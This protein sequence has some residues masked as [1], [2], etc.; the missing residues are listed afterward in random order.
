MKLLSI[1]IIFLFFLFNC[2]KK[3][4]RQRNPE[5]PQG[6]NQS[7]QVDNIHFLSA[8]FSWST[9]EPCSSNFFYWESK[10]Q[11]T[12]SNKNK[13][14]FNKFRQNYSTSLMGLTPETKY[15]FQVLI[16][17]QYNQSVFSDILDF[18]TS[19]DYSN[20]DLKGWRSFENMDYDS[21]AYYFSTYLSYEPK[22]FESLLGY[23]W[24]NIRTNKLDTAENLLESSKIIQND[25]NDVLSG[26]VLKYYMQSN[27]FMAELNGQQIH[28]KALDFKESQPSTY[29]PLKNPYYVFKYDSTYNNLD[30]ALILADSYYYQS[31]IEYA[32]FMVEFLHPNFKL[33]PHLPQSWQ[34]DSINYDTYENALNA[35]IDSLKNDYWDGDKHP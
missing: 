21:A 32:S 1:S 18:T 11:V 28:E 9:I 6:F 26:F 14:L 5:K 27:F 23:A 16:V 8:D 19:L 34:V 30:I 17:N 35:L 7:P 29:N 2:E 31:N 15:N 24:T 10:I 22:N 20:F 33:L 25:N 12:D 4:T 13:I 3:I